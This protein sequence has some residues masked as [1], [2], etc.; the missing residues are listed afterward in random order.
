[1]GG[2][3]SHVTRDELHRLRS[4]ELRSGELLAIGGHLASCA[5]CSELALS[6]TSIVRAAGELRAAIG[7]SD[8]HPDEETGLFAYVDGTLNADD[9]A[10]IDRHLETCPVCREDIADAR[11]ARRSIEPRLQQDTPAPRLPAPTGWTRRNV[12]HSRWRRMAAAA[13]VALAIG[14]T[15]IWIVRVRMITPGSMARTATPAPIQSMAVIPMKNVSISSGDDF[16]GV[17]LSD[18]LTTRLQGFPSLLVRPTSAVLEA[19]NAHDES[20]LFS[21]ALGVDGVIQGQF[22]TTGTMVRVSLQLIDLRTGYSLWADSV[23]GPRDDLL[24]LIDDLSSRTVSAIDQKLGMRVDTNGTAPRSSNPTAFEEYLRARAL[25]GSLIPAEYA[26]QIAHLQRAIALDPKFAAAYADL[27]IAMSIG[28]VRGLVADPHAIE[29][30]ERYARMAVSLDPRLAEAHLA[31][32]RALVRS[33]NR[34]RESARQE[35]AALRLNAKEPGPV[36]T[37]GSILALRGDLAR[38]RGTAE[39]LTRLDP[40]SNEARTRGYWY[41]N[42]ID[43]DDAKRAAADALARKSTAVAGNDIMANACILSGDFAEAR[44]YA[45]RVSALLPDH[46][47]ARSLGAMLAAENGDRVAAEAG[48]HSFEAEAL[49]NHWAAMRQALCY[50]KLGERDEAVRWMQRSV[51]LGN[52]SWYAWTRHPWMQP[53]QNDPRFQKI[54]AGIRADLDDVYPEAILAYQNIR[55]VPG[56]RF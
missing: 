42:M 45:S 10:T 39:Y 30:A 54:A 44:R 24:A 53:L 29:E 47:L 18:A 35:F 26:S 49:K 46:F 15:V 21:R 25:R 6:E 33:P 20:G 13:V 32:G 22:N 31:L 34:F 17:A 48:L 8:E 56:R 7:G 41:V 37:L 27:A 28:Q 12:G 38:T 5:E 11:Q 55:A 2:P 40:D 9:R 16:L 43:P 3:V 14:V 51:E 23:E 19:R 50:A 1:M 52:H 4:G 36:A